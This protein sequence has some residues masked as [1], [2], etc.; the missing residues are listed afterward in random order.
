MGSRF[1]WNGI[2]CLQGQDAKNV[3]MCS[4]VIPSNSCLTNPTMHLFYIPQYRTEMCTF[5]SGWCIAG[6]GTGALWDLGIKPIFRACST[7]SPQQCRLQIKYDKKITQ[8]SHDVIKTSLLRQNDVVIASCAHWE[9][10][11][12]FKSYLK[13]VMV[14]SNCTGMC[15][16]QRIRIL[17][18]SDSQWTW[19][20][21]VK[22][23]HSHSFTFPAVE[24]AMLSSLELVSS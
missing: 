1:C 21:H 7:A 2:S 15:V 3:K 14:Q 23:K 20:H 6:N 19:Q 12:C 10:M 13:V 8:R 11:K 4:S 5:C 24:I 9:W 16:V 22:D 18:Q 17:L